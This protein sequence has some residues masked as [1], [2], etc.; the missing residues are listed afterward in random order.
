MD[1]FFYKK[2]LLLKTLLPINLLQIVFVADRFSLIQENVCLLWVFT[3]IFAIRK[4]V[5]FVP[6]AI[7]YFLDALK[8]KLDHTNLTITMTK[9]TRIQWI[10]MVM[11]QIWTQI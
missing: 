1:K 3:S 5:L 11:A 8:L 7:N 6:I 4:Q 10:P 2:F 9:Q